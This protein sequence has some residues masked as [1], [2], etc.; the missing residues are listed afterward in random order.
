LSPST[1]DLL[2]MFTCK[3]PTMLPLL[4][5]ITFTMVEKIPVNPYKKSAS[6]VNLSP[7]RWQISMNDHVRKCTTNQKSQII[8]PLDYTWTS[9][10]F[11]TRS[12]LP[13]PSMDFTSCSFDAPSQWL[14]HDA[15][16]DATDMAISSKWC[17]A[18]MQVLEGDGVFIWSTSN[19]QGSPKFRLGLTSTY[20]VAL[21]PSSNLL[22]TGGVDDLRLWRMHNENPP[23]SKLFASAPT[24]SLDWTWF[25]SYFCSGHDHK[26]CLWSTQKTTPIRV[27]PAQE[28]GINATASVDVVKFHPTGSYIGMAGE[29]GAS[30]FDCRV[31][32]PARIWRPPQHYGSIT[33]MAFRED[34]Q[35]M[36]I[37]FDS[38]LEARVDLIKCQMK[39]E[40]IE[41][42]GAVWAV[43]YN[44]ESKAVAAGDFGISD[45]PDK[46]KRIL[47]VSVLR[48]TS[49][50]WGGVSHSKCAPS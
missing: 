44:Q 25:G 45:A 29:G 11:P 17:A 42:E 8:E 14:L 32:K 48:D 18:S 9:A 34:G 26:A 47:S 13:L 37:G 4:H 43:A 15:F 36:C 27:F 21:D 6:D 19:L 31:A 20:S 7:I 40:P 41:H 22:V 33:C 35:E 16:S 10:S 3:H 5:D 49:L 1:H 2:M 50:H 24:W 38:G 28:G 23:Q 30:M 12:V 39:E 46:D